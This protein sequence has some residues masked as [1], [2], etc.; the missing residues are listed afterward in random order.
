VIAE[1]HLHIVDTRPG[2]LGA[3]ATNLD[4][5]DALDFAG[6]K[7]AQVRRAVLWVCMWNFASK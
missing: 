6:Q 7:A 1:Q 2:Y 3:I 4:V 5:A